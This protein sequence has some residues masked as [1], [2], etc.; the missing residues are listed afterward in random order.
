MIFLKNSYYDFLSHYLTFGT[1]CKYLLVTAEN[2]QKVFCTKFL[3]KVINFNDMW[4]FTFTEVNI[5]KFMAVI[6][7]SR[8]LDTFS[9]LHI[10]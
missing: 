5:R 8:L 4:E 2:P 9:V 3:R 10:S 1:T 7:K 6:I